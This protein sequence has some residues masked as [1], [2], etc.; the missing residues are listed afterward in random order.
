MNKEKLLPFS[1]LEDFKESMCAYRKAC[2]EFG[3]DKSPDNYDTMMDAQVEMF[4]SVR[5]K[6]D[7]ETSS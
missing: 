4:N 5:E 2:I 6:C 7:N 1:F 3:E